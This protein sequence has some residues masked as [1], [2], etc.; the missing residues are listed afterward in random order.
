METQQKLTKEKKENIFRES[1]KKFNSDYGVLIVPV[2]IEVLDKESSN[3]LKGGK[4]DNEE[5]QNNY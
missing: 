5:I 4:K 1:I 2:E 3:V